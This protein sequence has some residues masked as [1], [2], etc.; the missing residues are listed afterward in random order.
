LGSRYGVGSNPLTSAAMRIGR[1]LASKAAI[2]PTPE[3]PAASPSHDAQA[4]SPS[5]V[6]APTPVT[7]TRGWLILLSRARV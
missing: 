1:P 4:V 5:G 2:G 3:R 6:T 7:T